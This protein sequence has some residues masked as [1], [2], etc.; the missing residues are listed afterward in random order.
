MARGK[1]GDAGRPSTRTNLRLRVRQFLARHPVLLLFFLTPGIPE[2]LSGSSQ[3]RGLLVAPPLFFIFLALNGAL[4]TPGVLLIR[5]AAVRWRKGWLTVF[6]LG[7]AYG[8]LEEG[9]ALS[10]LFNPNAGVVGVLGG[11]G[12]WMGVSWVWATGVLLVHV[13]FSVSLPLLLLGLALPETR[14]R[15]LLTRR[16]CAIAFAVLGADVAA[17]LAITAGGAHFWM[18]WPTLA[19]SML[20]ILALVIAAYRIPKSWERPSRSALPS[21]R[22]AVLVGASLFPAILLS[23]AVGGLVGL[24]AVGVVAAVLAVETG[25]FLWTWN[26]LRS[27]GA[28]GV[29]IAFALGLLLPLAVIGLLVGFPVEVDLLGV[30]LMA[31]FF[32]TLLRNYRRARSGHPLRSPSATSAG[33]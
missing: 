19:A 11:F 4:Y 30:V 24:P 3:L 33:I 5:E 23:Q 2:Y 8:L 27:P 29:Q 10:T 1:V 26:H 16:G 22:T 20:V 21:R 9:V 17:L 7:L 12:H 15:P 18:G 13:V 28:E 31:W 32:H 14:G 6:V 25:Y